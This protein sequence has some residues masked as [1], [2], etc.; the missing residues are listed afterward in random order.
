MR[1]KTI[2]A[3]QRVKEAREAAEEALAQQVHVTSELHQAKKVIEEKGE[4]HAWKTMGMKDQFRLELYRTR[5]RVGKDT[6]VSQ[7]IGMLTDMQQTQQQMQ[8]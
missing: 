3:E 2:H 8:K 4:Q 5:H 7:D 6:I 1:T